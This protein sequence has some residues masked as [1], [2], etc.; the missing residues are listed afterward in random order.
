MFKSSYRLLKID[1]SVM[2]TT[3]DESTSERIHSLDAYRAVLMS[4][5]IVIHAAIPFLHLD[6]NDA[7]ISIQLIHVSFWFVHVFRMPAFFILSGFF[8]ALLWSRYGGATMLM[9]R[10]ERVIAPLGFMMLITLPSWTFLTTLG[11]GISEGK[12]QALT[13]AIDHALKHIPAQKFEHLWFLYHLAWITLIAVWVARSIRDRELDCSWI[14]QRIRATFESPWRFV[15]LLSSIHILACAPLQMIDVPAGTQWMP[16]LGHLTYYA[17]FYAFGWGL[18]TSKTRLS[19]SRDRAWTLLMIGVISTIIYY[20]LRRHHKSVP[21]DLDAL[22]LEMFIIYGG[23]VVTWSVALF[24]IT[25]GLMGLFYRYASTESQTWRYLSDASYWVYLAHLPL[26][27]ELPKILAS[28]HLPLLSQYLITLVLTLVYCLVTYDLMV[29]S[30]F[31]G[32]SLNGRRYPRGP[33]QLRRLGIAL[34]LSAFIVLSAPLIKA[35]HVKQTWRAKGGISSLIPFNLQPNHRG[36]PPLKEDPKCHVIGRYAICESKLSFD[37]AHSHCAKMGAHL[38]TLETREEHEL[39]SKLMREKTPISWI[40][41]NDRTQ[42]GHWVNRKKRAPIYTA[43]APNQPDHH[44]EQEDCAY[45]SWRSQR[46]HDLNCET[47]IPFICE[48]PMKRSDALTQDTCISAM[49]TREKWKRD[50]AHLSSI[51]QDLFE[52]IDVLCPPQVTTSSAVKTP[53]VP[54]S[55]KALQGVWALDEGAVFGVSNFTKLPDTI[56]TSTQGRLQ[57]LQL[58]IMFDDEQIRL[59]SQAWA[60]E[61]VVRA[62]YQIISHL[63]DVI[64]I[65]LAGE[66]S[67]AS[68]HVIAGGSRLHITQ[69]GARWFL[70]RI[71]L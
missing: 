54:S 13:L 55:I 7:P 34:I 28:W 12:E 42:E 6:P 24:S 70:R 61:D 33:R 3:Q 10:F 45:T 5:G 62:S 57:A 35:Q 53:Q 36:S 51:E 18:Y 41:L 27:I 17:I 68:I 58:K 29:R 37:K 25:R 2:N 16:H 60:H 48:Q 31:I 38:L 19:S 40:D 52:M 71:N 64:T 47:S 26:A 59:I 65:I 43:W 21:F 49:T 23:G 69:G 8:A 32:A 66:T 11:A 20:S 39:I 50:R 4:L 22:T 56:K 15:L 46:W 1:M 44:Q 63:D 67:Q 9:N 30:T 14:L